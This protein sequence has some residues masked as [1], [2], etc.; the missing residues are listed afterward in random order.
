[1]KSEI[2]TIHP[3]VIKRMISKIKISNNGCW[4]WQGCTS[5]GYGTIWDRNK[6]QYAHR[7][8]Y[9]YFIGSIGDKFVCHKCDNR[10]CSNPFHLFLGTCS[11]NLNDAREKGRIKTAHCGLT[12]TKYQ[13]GCRCDKCKSI[14]KKSTRKK[15][16][17]LHPNAKKYNK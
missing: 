9:L 5:R 16:L 3:I 13:Q 11:D 1:M 15:W 7:I 2:K 12:L 4:E 14:H 10:L 6:M 17:I 8:S